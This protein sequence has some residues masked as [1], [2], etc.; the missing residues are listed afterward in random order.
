M[1][2]LVNVTSRAV[3]ITGCSSGIGRA[4]A[5]R[6][7]HAGHPVYATA[8]HAKDIADLEDLGIRTMPLDVT[9]PDSAAT[10]VDRVVREHGAV[11]VLVNNAGYALSGT[12]EE[13]LPE[14]ARAQFETNVFGPAEL[15]QRVLPGMRAQRSG[16]IVNVSSV[17]GRFAPPGGGFY[18]A[19]KHAMEA[20][21]DSLRLE[22][23]PFGIRVALIEPGPV[24]TAFADTTLGTVHDGLPEYGEFRGRIADWYSAVYLRTRR[25]V[26]GMFLAEP[27]DVARVIERVVRG[28]SARARY[29]VG[30]LARGLMLLRCT[31]PDPVFDAFVRWQFPKP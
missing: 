2:T 23:A 21:S 3:L 9:D 28:R 6:L 31:L 1:G 16:L 25:T 15:I 30:V 27:D 18:N 22:V 17:V 8:R 19:S 14:A 26:P 5:E 24:R 10:A 4:T 29:P 11:G 13:T 7:H 12:V 20:L